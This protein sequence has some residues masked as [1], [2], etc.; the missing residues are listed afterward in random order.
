MNTLTP[1]LKRRTD[2]RPVIMDDDVFSSRSVP[3]RTRAAVDDTLDNRLEKAQEEL[4]ALKAEQ[5]AA[6]RRREESEALEQT[7]KDFHAIFTQIA[8]E[9]DEAHD[10]LEREEQQLKKRQLAVREALR[11]LEPILTQIN[12]VDPAVIKLSTQ[13]A[14]IEQTIERLLPLAESLEAIT[15]EL[16]KITNTSQKPSR[17]LAWPQHLSGWLVAGFAFT[18]PLILTAIGLAWWWHRL[19]Q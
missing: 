16:G 3:S 18:L 9:S 5:I 2:L 7:K 11:R 8:R 13:K 19:H 4:A 15:H 14:P 10:V 17:G 12:R 1:P 6:E